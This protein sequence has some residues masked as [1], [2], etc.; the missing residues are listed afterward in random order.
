[1]SNITHYQFLIKTYNTNILQKH[2]KAVL[3]LLGYSARDQ[4]SSLTN[5][6]FNVFMKM[7][8]V[9]SHCKHLIKTILTRSHS[10]SFGRKYEKNLY[11]TSEIPYWKP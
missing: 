9:G 1:M 2:N 3:C 7:Y 8:F 5:V 6:F 4:Q 11:F 10:I